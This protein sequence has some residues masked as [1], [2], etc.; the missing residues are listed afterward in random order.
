M[1]IRNELDVGGAVGFTDRPDKEGS[2]H[3]IDSDY[4]VRHTG[5]STDWLRVIKHL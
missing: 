3:W 2:S 4:G 5:S 1:A